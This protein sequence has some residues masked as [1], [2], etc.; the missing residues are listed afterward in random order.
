MRVRAAA[1]STFQK[2]RNERQEIGFTLFDDGLCKLDVIEAEFPPCGD[3][4]VA[5]FEFRNYRW[6]DECGSTVIPFREFRS[7]IN[8]NKEL[9]R[10]VAGFGRIPDSN[11]ERDSAAFDNYMDLVWA[12]QGF[13]A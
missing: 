12:A 2:V 1:D 7:F 13:G 5:W 11:T 3:R 6:H 8:E 4:V 10:K 9:I